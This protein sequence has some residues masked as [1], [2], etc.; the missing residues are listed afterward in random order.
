MRC[1]S[2][3]AVVREGEEHCPRCGAPMDDHAPPDAAGGAVGDSPSPLPAAPVS[4]VSPAT[5]RSAPSGLSGPPSAPPVWQDPPSNASSSPV[6][7]ELDS[8]LEVARWRPLVHWLLALPHYFVVQALNTIQGLL[9]MVAFFAILFTA[10]IP[11]GMFDFMVTVM[12][13]QWRVSTYCYV[14]REPYAP[15]DFSSSAEDPGTD[16][17]RLSITYPERLSRWRIFVKWLLALPHYFVLVFLSI[18]AVVSLFIAM[19]AI[20]ITGRWPEGLRRYVVGVSRWAVRVQAY[21]FLLTDSYP[22]FALD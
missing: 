18:G 16:P 15:F 8:P 17:G 19:I 12:R 13:Y 3:R 5:G 20:I 14:M 4:P 10:R 1:M 7:V 6:S 2:C 22:P 21:I 11:R 9:V